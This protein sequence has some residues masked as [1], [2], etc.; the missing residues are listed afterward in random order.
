MSKKKGHRENEMKTVEIPPTQSDD[1]QNLWETETTAS[2]SLPAGWD[3]E[4]TISGPAPAGWDDVTHAGEAPV[5]WDG[6]PEPE[7][8][9]DVEPTLEK[10]ASFSNVHERPRQVARPRPPESAPDSETTIAGPPADFKL[11][12]NQQRP[13]ADS[14][15]ER[16]LRPAIEIEVRKA[17]ATGAL[18]KVGPAY[19]IWT[20]N[21]VYALD[22]RLRCIDVIDL[23]T[24]QTDHRH[25]FLGGQL[26]GG[27][28]RNGDTTELT[29]PLP[30]P[31]ADAMF[32]TGAAGGHARLMVTSRVTRV[33][34]LVQVV[35]A[36]QAD[37]ASTLDFIAQSTRDP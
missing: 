37:V 10:R 30:V 9:H 25:P 11:A 7:V 14:A 20:K 32:Q 35:R 36:S 5:A 1:A 18:R 8:E 28:K 22:A 27:Q 34:M 33:M 3:S 12:P 2:A 17:S 31:G 23:T 13:K 16:A 24:G 29:F 15:D 4:S 26:V 21:R 6:S 19:E